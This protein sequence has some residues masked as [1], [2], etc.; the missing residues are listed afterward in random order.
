MVRNY[1]EYRIFIVYTNFTNLGFWLELLTLAKLVVTSIGNR[2]FRIFAYLFFYM[3]SHVHIRWKQILFFLSTGTL[4]VPPDPSKMQSGRVF[5]KKS[6]LAQGTQRR[7]TPAL[8]HS[9]PCN[10]LVVL[11]LVKEDT[12]F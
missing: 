7:D 10:N 11:A 12:L 1:S 4:L 9:G 8:A 2:S 3:R 6:R 5:F